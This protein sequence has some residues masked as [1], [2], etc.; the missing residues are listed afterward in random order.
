MKVT[1][2]SDTEGEDNEEDKEAEVVV[3]V[4]QGPSSSFSHRHQDK[5]TGRQFEHMQV[6]HNRLHPY[7]NFLGSFIFF[8]H[9]GK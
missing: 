2:D 1:V 6:S 3:E 7:L 5:I 4:E 9:V 8:S